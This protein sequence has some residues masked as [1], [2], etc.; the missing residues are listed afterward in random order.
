MFETV[1]PETFES[2]SKLVLY[3]TLPLSI[4]LHALGLSAAFVIAVWNVVFPA[5]SPRVVRAYTL[6]TIPDPPERSSLPLPA[7]NSPSA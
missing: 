6:A 3:E 7:R 5:Q 1:M 2:R 4:A